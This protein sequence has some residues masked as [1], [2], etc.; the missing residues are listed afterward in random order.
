MLLVA[1][2]KQ[3]HCNKQKKTQCEIQH[4]K[5]TN[6]TKKYYLLQQQTK[7]TITE[8]AE[9]LATVVSLKSRSKSWGEGG[10]GKLRSKKGGGSRGGTTYLIAAATVVVLVSGEGS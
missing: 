5:E 4:K 8:L 1:T 6:A 3:G 7:A 10:G 9:T 2:A